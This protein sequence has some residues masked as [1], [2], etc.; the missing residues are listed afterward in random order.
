MV[1][2]CSPEMPRRAFM[3]AIAGGLL[4]APLA[5]EAQ[6]AGKVFQVGL[7]SIGTDPTWRIL[8]KPFIEAMS[9]LGYVEGRNLLIRPAFADGNP[10]RL[11]ALVA[12]LINA[13]VDVIVTT[14]PRETVAAKRASASIPIVMT[15]V[16]DP[17]AQGFVASLSRPGGNITGLTSV[18]PGLGQKYVELLHEALPLATRFAVV[19]SPP[20]PLSE[21]RQELEAAGRLLGITL[22]VARVSG[23]DD[24]D[25]VLARAKRDG[26]A[27][28]IASNDG[29]TWRY[30]KSL[31]Q[32]A[33]KHRL[34]AIY[35][36]REYVNEGGLMTYSANVADLRRRA[37]TYVEKILKGARPADL[38]V[39]QPTN[40]EL[41]I[42]L[43]TAKALGLTIPPSLLQRADQVIE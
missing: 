41:V 8:W 17:V 1:S 4:A 28:F 36:A 11:P 37:A 27:G 21:T 3:A 18:V 39:E 34:P 22:S 10:E 40:F 31:V 13:K 30:R 14:G 20:N 15:V 26:A 12:E 43:K 5:A 32:S 29:V 23:P 6:P 42:N 25:G 9:G 24:F 2:I 38:P 33:L 7:L 35:W 19:A 16:P